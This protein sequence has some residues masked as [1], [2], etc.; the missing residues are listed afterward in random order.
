MMMV[1]MVVLVVFVF[2]IESIESGF[3]W[4]QKKRS[5]YN[6]TLSSRSSQLWL[7][8]LLMTRF[9]SFFFLFF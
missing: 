9:F 2:E 1:V 8:S 6:L 4:L 7:W 3:P 5:V